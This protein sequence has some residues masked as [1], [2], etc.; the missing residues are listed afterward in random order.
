[1]FSNILFLSLFKLSTICNCFSTTQIFFLSFVKI[2]TSMEGSC[3]FSSFKF[4]NAIIF[5]SSHNYRSLL[6]QTVFSS[7][8]SR[9]AIRFSIVECPKI[10]SSKVHSFFFFISL[11]FIAFVSFHNNFTLLG[12]CSNLIR[13]WFRY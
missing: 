6:M 8:M 9:C 5:C 3:I 4:L 10:K 1:M 7:A 2:V 12:V 13:A 11:K